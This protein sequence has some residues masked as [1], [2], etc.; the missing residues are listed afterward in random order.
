MEQT[1]SRLALDFLRLCAWLLI[2]VMIFVPLERICALHP[3][4]VFRRAFLS[5]LIY[6]F[7]NN[8]IPKA[9][10]VV[11]M[12]L[13][14][15]AV[16]L[17]VPGGFYARVAALPLGIR[18]AVALVVGD[19]GFYWGHRW[20]HEIPLLWRFHAIHHSA[21]EMDW[22]V[23]TRTHPLDMVFTRLCGFVPIYAL[24]LSQPTGQTLDYV[25]LLV[26]FTSTLWGFFIHANLRW[27]FGL[28]E[29]VIATPAFHHWHHTYEGPLNRNFSAMLP[30]VD[31]LFRTHYVQKQEWP[32]RYGTD[33]LVPSGLSGQLLE[34][35]SRRGGA[36][37]EAGAQVLHRIS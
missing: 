15:W 21:E 13:V 26:V 37:L 34:P 11:P 25:S 10:L 22:L 19:V 16:H 27:R 29:W 7:L 32:I 3:R 6:Y 1:S 28:L 36:G 12:A 31:V 24:G 14:G 33:T 2:I 4:K 23:N 35:L 9:I 5:D 17:V 18:F 8:L 20:S 30:W